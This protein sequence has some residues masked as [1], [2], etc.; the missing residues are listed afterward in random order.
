MEGAMQSY[1]ELA[2]L[3]QLCAK[4]ARVTTT[5]KVASEFWRMAKEYQKKAADVDSGALPEIGPPSSWLKE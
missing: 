5:R 2:E 4:Q 3:A 1:K